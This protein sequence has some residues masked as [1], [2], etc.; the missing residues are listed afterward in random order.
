MENVRVYIY[1]YNLYIYICTI[2]TS[3]SLENHGF[4]LNIAML[5]YWGKTR[6]NRPKR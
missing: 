4:P 5:I 2:R 6:L 1:I 3:C